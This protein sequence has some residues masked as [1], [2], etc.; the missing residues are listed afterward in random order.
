MPASAY[1][2][3]KLITIHHAG[4]LWK[5][6]DDPLR[7]LRGLQKYGQNQK[8]WPDLP[9]HFLISPDGTAYEGRPTRFKPET[10]TNYDTTGH[11]GIMLWGN[12]QDQRVSIEQLTTA[13]RLTAAL[14]RD[15]SISPETIAGHKD[16]AQT[17]CPGAD[18][19]RYIESGLFREWVQTALA[20]QN[21]PIALLPPLPGGPTAFVSQSPSTRPAPTAT[22]MAR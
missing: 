3:P 14:C 8:N 12:F 20:G 13:V 7:K 17:A 16:R 22:N 21:P 4:E 9:Y 18:L 11:V 19:Y 15:L 6:T 10:N 5:P 2:T 1:Q